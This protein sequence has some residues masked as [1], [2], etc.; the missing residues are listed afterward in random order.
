MGGAG[1]NSCG[2]PEEGGPSLKHKNKSKNKKK[3]GV[4]ESTME[5]S[6]MSMTQSGTNQ[7]VLKPMKKK[8]E[9]ESRELGDKKKVAIEY[10]T[11]KKKRGTID[12]WED[13]AGE[14]PKGKV[15]EKERR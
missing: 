12:D 10:Y 5:Q 9:K 2:K 6:E 4:T 3:G 13:I 14:A 15:V 11:E 8:G 7:I 1:C